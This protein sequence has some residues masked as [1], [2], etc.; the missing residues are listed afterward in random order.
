MDDAT[1]GVKTQPTDPQLPQG[2]MMQSGG[3]SVERLRTTSSNES[4]SPMEAP[5]VAPSLPDVKL[6]PEVK[7]V[8]SIRNELNLGAELQGV[9]SES[10]PPVPTLPQQPLISEPATKISMPLPP[11]PTSPESLKKFEKVIKRTDKHS[12]RAWIG[13]IQLKLAKRVAGKVF[14]QRAA[15]QI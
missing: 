7:D 11:D 1:A 6:A 13:T 8:I 3:R 15:G 9:V 10:Q 4:R 12:A 2:R 14:R 5:L